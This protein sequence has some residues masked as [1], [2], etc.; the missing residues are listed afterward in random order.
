MCVCV[1]VCDSWLIMVN[2]ASAFIS[3][4]CHNWLE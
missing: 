2:N 4:G 1:C 3:N